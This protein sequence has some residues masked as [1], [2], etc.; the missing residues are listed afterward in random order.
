MNYKITFLM[1]E[2]TQYTSYTANS[3]ST[4]IKT[5][6]NI[7]LYYILSVLWIVCSMFVDPMS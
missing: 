7:T 4:G 3:M 2:I 6:N 5:M 1:I